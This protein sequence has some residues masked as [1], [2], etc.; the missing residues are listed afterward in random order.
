MPQPD[1][2]SIAGRLTKQARGALL[3]A[4]ADGSL[5]LRFVRWW[6]VNARTRRSLVNRGLATHVWSGVA[7]NDAG[8]AVRQ[9]LEE[10]DNG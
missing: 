7:L 1:I 4:E 3:R 10:R 5:G 9:Y 2:S 8:E 6:H